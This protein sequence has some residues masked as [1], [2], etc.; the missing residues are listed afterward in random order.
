MDLIGKYLDAVERADPIKYTGRVV[1][2]QGLLVESRG[3]QAVVG[4]L[5]QILIP[6]LD[7]VAWAEVAGLRGDTVQLM[8]YSS[9]DG[10]EIGCVV[11]ATGDMLQVPVSDKLLGRTLDSMGRPADGKGEISSPSFYPAVAVPPDALTRR[12]IKARIATGVRAF[13]GLL[14]LGRGQRIGI[15]AGSGVGK[16]TL[17]G[18]IARNTNADVNVI[19]LIGERGR[20]VREFL[21]NDLGEEGLARSVIIVSTSDTPPLARLRGAYVAT[22]VAEYFRDQGKDVMLLFDSV[23]RF[24][25]A[26]REIGLAI[27]EPPATRGYTPSVFDSLPKLLERSGTSDKGSI[28]GVY[29]ILVDGDDMDEPI[30]DTVRGILDGH[31]VLTRRLAERYHY[32]AIDILKSISRLSQAVTGPVTQKAMGMIRRLI[33][34]YEES[35]DMINIG[36]YVKGSNPAIDEAISKHQ[37]IEEFLIQAIEEQSTTVETLRRLG[38]IA[39]LSIPSAEIG[40]YDHGSMARAGNAEVA[41]P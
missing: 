17:L 39:G 22:A 38:E 28:T 4:E 3:P 8:A 29:T 30:A 9:L 5:C 33:A 32:P 14:P 12:R 26:Q 11:V 25:R 21:E 37:A 18:M 24:A 20:E 6:R 7:K 23:T 19:A 41:N 34:T 15:F 16:S 10:I 31:V 35:E 2:V 36:A 13:D 40:A 1:R 27:G